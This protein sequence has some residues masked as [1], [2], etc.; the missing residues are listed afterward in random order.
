VSRRDLFSHHWSRVGQYLRHCISFLFLQ[1]NLL[2]FPYTSIF[3]SAFHFGVSR[4]PPFQ[5]LVPCKQWLRRLPSI[6]K[7]SPSS[8]ML[9]LRSLGFLGLS[10]IIHC[11]A[12]R[13]APL[14][15][16][17]DLR[18]Q[19]FPGYS[20]SAQAA[21][22][23][24][25]PH[26]T[27]SS[28]AS[29]SYST[30]TASHGFNYRIGASFSAKGRRFNPKTDHYFY[31]STNKTR[32]IYD[33]GKPTSGQDAFFVS[34]LGNGGSVAFGV[35]DGVGGWSDSGIDSAHFSHGLCQ[36]MIEVAESAN[37]STE[38]PL[39]AQKLLQNGYDA[40]VADETI[41]G[42][43]STACIAVG[44]DNGNLEVAKYVSS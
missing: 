1:R 22:E 9:P 36:R 42:G 20:S 16:Q 19:C 24:R 38:S 8:M 26:H 5:S 39:G 18:P 41:A 40:V 17:Q 30:T 44:R 27:A 21:G 35:A 37:T 2:S 33:T 10:P 15:S 6:H 7:F 34:R 28:S 13:F 23:A 43:G 12:C 3:F 32:E 29:R 11:S 4:T 14:F 25:F 31:D